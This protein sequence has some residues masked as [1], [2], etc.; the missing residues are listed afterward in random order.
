MS[1]DGLLLQSSTVSD[2]VQYKFTQSDSFTVCTSTSPASL[3]TVATISTGSSGGM[4]TT[5]IAGAY[6]EFVERLP[7]EAISDTS[8]F[9]PLGLTAASGSD[10]HRRDGF[11]AGN[12][13][14][15]FQSTSVLKS[16]R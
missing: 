6:V 3:D 8:D 10:L 11:E 12:A 2:L 4:P 13:D 9:K 14:K 16:H 5:A 1:P 7:L 15:I